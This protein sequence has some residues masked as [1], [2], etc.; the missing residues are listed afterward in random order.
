MRIARLKTI[1]QFENLKKRDLILVKWSDYK[2]KHDKGCKKVML[3]KIYENKKIDH[4]IICQKRNNHYFNYLM[5]LANESQ[6][7]QVYSVIF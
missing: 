2:A 3:Y 6:A 7:K 1:E 4:E 5:Y